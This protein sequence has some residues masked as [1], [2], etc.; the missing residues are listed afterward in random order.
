MHRR[1][2]PLIKLKKEYE[3]IRGKNLI[4]TNINGL[5]VLI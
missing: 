5:F 1:Q 4:T 3:H 2:L